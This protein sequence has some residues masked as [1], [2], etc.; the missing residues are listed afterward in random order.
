MPPPHPYVLLDQ[1]PLCRRL[2]YGP[3]VAHDASHGRQGRCRLAARLE[4]RAHGALPRC[5]ALHEARSKH[6]GTCWRHPF[7][8]PHHTIRTTSCIINQDRS[9]LPWPSVH[10][11]VS[12]LLLSFHPT[13]TPLP[14]CRDIL[15]A[16]GAVDLVCQLPTQALLGVL[17]SELLWCVLAPTVSRSSV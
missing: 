16:G 4:K 3:H 9:V 12:A 15:T 14:Q 5:A 17:S 11:V 8:A 6:R 10:T 7:A 13:L 2:V 1:L